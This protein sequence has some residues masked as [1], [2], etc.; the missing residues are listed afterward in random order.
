MRVLNLAAPGTVS[1]MPAPLLPIA[2]VR[3]HGSEMLVGKAHQGKPQSCPGIAAGFA[4]VFL[5][6][7]GKRAGFPV[8][9]PSDPGGDFRWLDGLD[10]EAPVSY[11]HLT[12]PTKA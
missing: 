1:L 10:A 8:Y 6:F 2:V 4:V 9:F 3:L 11:T 5:D 7:P 12:L